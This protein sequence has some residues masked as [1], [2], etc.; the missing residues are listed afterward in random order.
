MGSPS[1]TLRPFMAYLIIVSLLATSALSTPTN[2]GA[3]LHNEFLPQSGPHIQDEIKCYA[4]PF[5]GIGFLSHLLTYYTAG[6]LIFG[7]TP[8][9]PRPGEHFA[10]RITKRLKRDSTISWSA[11]S[12]PVLEM[13][14]G[15]LSLIV[16]IPITIMTMYACRRRWEFVLIA[17]WKM[18]LTL[19]ISVIPIS[20]GNTM[21]TTIRAHKREPWRVININHDWTDI[22]PWTG[23]YGLGIIIGTSWI[24]FFR[25]SRMAQLT[26]N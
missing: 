4:L 21:N 26:Y 19:T 3:W 12:G 10:K 22:A 24:G 23:I 9:V 15:A 17:I 16:A 5:G 11:S 6:M 8:L 1:N 25:E 20:L 18:L 13:L 14:L 7:L 2:V